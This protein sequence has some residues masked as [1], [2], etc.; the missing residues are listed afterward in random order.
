VD[1]RMIQILL[2]YSRVRS[3]KFYAGAVPGI[4]SVLHTWNGTLG[5]HPHVHLLITDG[6]ITDE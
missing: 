4:L 1:I 3:T 2:G 5:Y 6:G